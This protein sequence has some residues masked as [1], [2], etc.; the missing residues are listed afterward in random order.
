MC[1]FC[2]LWLQFCLSLV[3]SR[4][5]NFCALLVQSYRGGWPRAPGVIF[6]GGGGANGPRKPFHWLIWCW[7]IY[8]LWGTF[9][10]VN[11]Q[12]CSKENLTVVMFYGLSHTSHQYTHN[13]MLMVKRRKSRLRGLPLDPERGAMV[14][15]SQQ[16]MLFHFQTK[17][18]MFP[19]LVDIFF[20][21]VVR[22]NFLCT[23]WWTNLTKNPHVHPHR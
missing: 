10:C 4:M 15:P 2:Y 17:Q 13:I 16:T 6:F 22:T 8:L 11:Y 14:F 1:P 19:P 18:A 3:H 23:T 9:P 5:W 21:C 20:L 12:W 7:W